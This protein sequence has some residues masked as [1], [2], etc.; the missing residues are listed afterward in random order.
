MA[1]HD[2][3]LDPRF[4]WGAVGGAM[5]FTRVNLAISGKEQRNEEWSES[6]GA[7]DVAHSLKFDSEL[8]DLIDFY[9]SRKGRLHTFRF[10]DLTD[11]AL[12]S[13]ESLGSFAGNPTDTVQLQKTYTSGGETQVRTITKPVDTTDSNHTLDLID[14]PYDALQIKVGGV[15]KIEGVDY[16]VD[17]STGIITNIG[18]LTG[19]VTIN[20]GSFHC[21]V[22][23]DTDHMQISKDAYNLNTWGNIPIIELLHE[24]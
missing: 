15:L 2:I 6:K 21:H 13:G 10:C 22:R 24:S 7:W 9:R 3:L 20:Q 8:S 18:S 4:S 5:F 14:P 23:F 17:Y 11:Y 1:F 19:A 12:L 16:S